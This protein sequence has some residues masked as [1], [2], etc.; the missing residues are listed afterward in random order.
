METWRRDPYAIYA[1]HILRLKPLD[2]L[3]ATVGP[4]ERGTIVHKALEIFVTKF[5]GELPVDAAGQ[6]IAI[7][8]ALF[9][10]EKIPA[11]VLAI[12]RPRFA[13]AAQWFVGQER[14][15]RSAIARS[16]VETEGT[17]VV[18]GPEGDFTLHGR[19][20]RIDLLNRGG[21][22]ILDYKTGSTPTDK[23]VK[24]LLSPQLPLEGAI[25][26]SGGFSSVGAIEP[27]EL[28]YVRFIGGAEP[29]TWRVININAQEMSDRA[30]DW[31]TERVAR[32]D[33]EATPYLTRAIA[34]RTDIVGDYDHLARVG[35]WV[36]ERL[37]DWDA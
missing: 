25:A 34:Y 4:L 18:P 35:E 6:L 30:R 1:R 32:Y 36:V 19:A 7:A 26:A 15:R 22:A 28:V 20:D 14:G 17:L 24:T 3:D 12:W 5:P 21:A 11:A 8:D 23:Q 27:R 10:E 33:Q 31:L 2:Q 37:D 13:H 16:Y 29:G 9:Q